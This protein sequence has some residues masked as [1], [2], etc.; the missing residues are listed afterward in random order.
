MVLQNLPKT[1]LQFQLWNSGVTSSQELLESHTSA[2][3]V[4]LRLILVKF[5][6]PTLIPG[7]PRVIH[8]NVCRD[9][10]II[11]IALFQAQGSFL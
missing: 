5:H 4:E 1:W 7:D 11:N 3:T 2:P 9:G 6:S 8:S 10:Q